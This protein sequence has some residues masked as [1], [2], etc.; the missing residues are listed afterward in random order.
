[1]KRNSEDRNVFSTPTYS[2]L[3]FL[4]L[5]FPLFKTTYLPNLYLNS[6]AEYG[7]RPSWAGLTYRYCNGFIQW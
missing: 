5:F 1:M 4:L 3:L 2:I 7:T 6:W